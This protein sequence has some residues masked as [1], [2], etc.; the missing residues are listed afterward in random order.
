MTDTGALDTVTAPPQVLMTLPLGS[1]ICDGNTRPAMA[2]SLV[3]PWKP[4]RL[5]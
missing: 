5:L 2:S 4:P 1:T 3:M